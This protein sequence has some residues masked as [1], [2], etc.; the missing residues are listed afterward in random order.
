[1][2]GCHGVSDTPGTCQ[3]TDC[4]DFEKPL[5]ECD[6]PDGQSHHQQMTDEEEE[7]DD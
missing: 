3:T 5:H 4:K 6:C 2:G 7:H 1:M